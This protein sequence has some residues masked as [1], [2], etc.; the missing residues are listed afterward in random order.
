MKYQRYQGAAGLIVI[1]WALIIAG[2][3]VGLLTK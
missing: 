1:M 3:I 2:L